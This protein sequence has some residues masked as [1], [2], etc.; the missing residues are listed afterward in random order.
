[1][2]RIAFVLKKFRRFMREHPS[3]ASSEARAAFLKIKLSKDEFV[4]CGG[5]K[6]VSKHLK[7]SFYR[8]VALA[9]RDMEDIMRK[10]RFNKS[11]SLAPSGYISSDAEDSE[12]DVDR[13]D[14]CED[15][16]SSA[17]V[18]M[19]TNDEIDEDGAERAEGAQEHDG[20]DSESE[21]E[22]VD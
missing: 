14:Q 16:N 7:F 22:L 19:N 15:D 11:R 4:E 12:E 21:A 2:K 1:M 10:G 9:K 17:G 6:T 5:H 18:C 8:Q 3:L 20:E 13:M